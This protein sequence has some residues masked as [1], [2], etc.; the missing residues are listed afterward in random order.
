[1]ETITGFGTTP[2]SPGANGS[3][4]FGQDNAGGGLVSS[5][6]ALLLCLVMLNASHAI[7]ERETADTV[8]GVLE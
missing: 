5:I 6:F 4:V 7:F 2:P 1:M 3:A 8:S